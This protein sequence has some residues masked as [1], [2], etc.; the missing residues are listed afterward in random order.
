MGRGTI[1][2]I[3]TGLFDST[4]AMGRTQYCL[5]VWRME[6]KPEMQSENPAAS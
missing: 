3:T 6:Q 1:K 4:G 5:R 2:R